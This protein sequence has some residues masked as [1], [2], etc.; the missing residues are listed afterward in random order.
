MSHPG[1]GR[2]WSIYEY[3][4]W[5]QKCYG[6]ER[7]RVLVFNTTF[8]NISV[9]SWRSVLLVEETGVPGENHR[10]VASHWQTLSHNVVSSTPCHEQVLNTDSIG[11][12]KSNYHTIM[13]T[14]TPDDFGV[15]EWILYTKM[16]WPIFLSVW[17]EQVI[18]G[19]ISG[20]ALGLKWMFDLYRNHVIPLCR[21]GMCH[22]HLRV[23]VMLII[24]DPT[25]T[26]KYR[27]AIKALFLYINVCLIVRLESHSC[28]N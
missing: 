4:F 3:E 27:T 19:K 7:T 20:Q 25:V 24:E 8:N 13:T 5:S 15:R 21:P 12:C 18:F 26:V 6:H 16:L 9:I 23:W 2:F 17:I 14:M 10:P 1:P 22:I 11:S 28:I